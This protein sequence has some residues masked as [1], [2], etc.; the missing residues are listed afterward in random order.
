VE[1]QVDSAEAA[2]YSREIN[3]NGQSMD[4]DGKGFIRNSMS[5]MPSFSGF[6]RSAHKYETLYSTV[7]LA[8]LDPKW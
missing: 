1:K 5:R 4:V 3:S 2:F 7:L 6:G 8:G